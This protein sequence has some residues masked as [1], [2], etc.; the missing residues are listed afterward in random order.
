MENAIRQQ[1]HVVPLVF[2]NE[3]IS[4]AYCFTLFPS[5]LHWRTKSW[6]LYSSLAR[7]FL[8]MNGANWKIIDYLWLAKLPTHPQRLL[9]RE[10]KQ[11]RF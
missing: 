3:L 9:I 6:T 4:N 1:T 5:I 7:W 8:I 10:L 2:A 11:Q